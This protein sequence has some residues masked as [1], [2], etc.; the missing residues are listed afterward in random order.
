MDPEEFSPECHFDSAEDLLDFL[1][2]HKPHWRPDQ[3]WPWVFRGQGRAEWDLQPN[4]F[5]PDARLEFYVGGAAGPKVNHFHQVHA[6]L[7]IVANFVTIASGYGLVLPPVAEKFYHAFTEIKQHV[8]NAATGTSNAGWPIQEWMPLFALAQ[9]YGLPTRLLDWTF[10]PRVAA[11]FA[12]K[13]AVEDAS[14]PGARLAVWAFRNEAIQSWPLWGH[15]DTKERVALYQIPAAT[16]PNLLA[17]R[18]VLSTIHRRSRGEDPAATTPLN[19]LLI[20]TVAGQTEAW[21]SEH[22]DDAPIMYKLTLPSSEAP[23]LL[24]LLARNQVSGITLFPG[25]DGVVMGMYERSL[26]DR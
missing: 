24:R 21:R 19:Q 17:Q 16:N 26:W 20:A 15:P 3:F 9:H 18:G 6:E 25:F 13:R 23:K 11:Y 14:E 5:R 10:D 22:Q 4:A 7:N 12:A 2:L 8:K 1:N